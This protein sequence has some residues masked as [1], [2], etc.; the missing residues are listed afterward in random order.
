MLLFSK[1]CV[2][3]LNPKAPSKKKHGLRPGPIS[4]I[5]RSQ[6]IPPFSVGLPHTKVVDLVTRQ[7]SLVHLK[8][9]Q[10]A[11]DDNFATIF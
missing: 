9:S 11:H 8:D 2:G 4:S 6:K 5:A 7:V 3:R 1:L 10:D